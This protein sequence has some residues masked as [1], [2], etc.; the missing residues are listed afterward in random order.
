[1]QAAAD[2]ISGSMV[3]VLGLERP[4]LEPLCNQAREGEVLQLANLLC[5]GNIVVSGHKG[6]CERLTRLAEAAGAMRVVPLAVAGAFH[7]PLME[8]ARE[9]LRRALETVE[10]QNPRIPV[11]SNV[12]SLPHDDPAKIRT[13][14]LEQLVSPVLWED[15][16]RR[17]I[18][19]HGVVQ[20][21]E[22]GS[23]RV[24]RGLLKRIDRNVACENIG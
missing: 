19:E 21:Y 23:G 15:S 8:A 3:S 16:M 4:V 14:L 5:P 1:M 17:M 12:D 13:L 7:T 18:T 11:V 2:S 24:L 9:R 20:F 22:L 6:A 10:F